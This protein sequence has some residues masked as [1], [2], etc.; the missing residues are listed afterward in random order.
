MS[1]PLPCP[2]G[3]L[4]RAILRGTVEPKDEERIALHLESCEQCR[5]TLDLLSG[6]EGEDES[7]V[8]ESHCDDIQRDVS[9]VFDPAADSSESATPELQTVTE[10]LKGDDL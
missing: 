3:D 10:P 5:R 9:P 6:G 8:A 1:L 7:T 2:E 4:L